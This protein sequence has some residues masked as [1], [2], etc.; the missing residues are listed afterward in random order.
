MAML[1]YQGVSNSMIPSMFF[2]CDLILVSPMCLSITCLYIPLQVITCHYM[3]LQPLYNFYTTISFY[4]NVYSIHY[5]IRYRYQCNISIYLCI[6]LYIYIQF[7]ILVYVEYYVTY[8]Y[9][10]IQIP[11]DIPILPEFLSTDPGFAIWCRPRVS[12][13][14]NM[15]SVQ[16]R[17]GN[18]WT[19]PKLEQ[20]N[21]EV[22]SGKRL[23]KLLL[24]IVIQSRVFHSKNGKLV[25]E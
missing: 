20:E 10:Y 3:P 16:P 17:A 5:V 18:F 24:K 13:V 2:L 9:I 8:L 23:H 7:V 19:R 12:I 15:G 25:S 21:W 6:Y 4:T 14:G 11:D 1:N 22:S